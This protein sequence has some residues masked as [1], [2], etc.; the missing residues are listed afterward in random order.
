MQLVPRL[1]G[2]GADVYVRSP[3][4]SPETM[5]NRHCTQGSLRS[6]PQ[7]ERELRRLIHSGQC[8]TGST[9]I[10]EVA[11]TSEAILGSSDDRGLASLHEANMLLQPSF[12]LQRMEAFR[13][14]S[15]DLTFAKLFAETRE[16]IVVASVLV[17]C[18]DGALRGH[19]IVLDFWRSL[20]FLGA[21]NPDE[22]TLVG[23]KGITEADVCGGRLDESLAN[24]G[25]MRLQAVRL[26]MEHVPKQRATKLSTYERQTC[27]AS[28]IVGGFSWGGNSRRNVIVRLRAKIR[29]RAIES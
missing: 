15:A 8:G 12:R 11:V 2:D 17:Q 5:N 22:E 10:V 18:K 26:L 21:G 29:C 14:G 28:A 19:V 7:L 25:V 3:S 9:N 27:M 1:N 6:Y 23:V 24:L 13:D 20:I 4:M 16:G